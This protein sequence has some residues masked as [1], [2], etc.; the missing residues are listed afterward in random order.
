MTTAATMSKSWTPRWSIHPGVILEEHLEARELSQAEFAR[1][2][3]LT[4]KL[5]STIIAGKNPVTA[6]SAIAFERVL[7][8]RAYIWVRMQADWELHRARSEE[9]F[10]A[11]VSDWLKPFPISE[12]KKRGVLPH[13]KEETRLAEAMLSFLELG[14][15]D[16]YQA[17]MRE[18]RP[19]YRHART[20]ESSPDELR[21]WLQLGKHEAEKVDSVAF[22]RDRF[23]ACAQRVRALTKLS[24]EQFVPRLQTECAAAGVRVVFVKPFK[25][26]KLS[27]A[28][29]WPSTDTGPIVQLSLRHKTNDHLW[30][31]FFHEAA[32]VVL[33]SLDKQQVFADDDQGQGDGLE[34]EADEWAATML[35]PKEAFS[36]LKREVRECSQAAMSCKPIINQWATELGIHAGILVGMLQHD[37]ELPWSHLN[38]MKQR[39]AWADELPPTD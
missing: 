35:V 31:S 18:W 2:A 29:F 6:E 13:V 14:S 20:F 32:H 26:T 5:V 30:F 1:R 36:E 8:M 23:V 17:A 15:I 24:A 10:G 7:G 27:G 37:G 28:A 19:Q 33:H 3:G 4:K 38:A 21:V 12:L 25:G 16:A 39:L 22:D 34:K 11:S 9:S